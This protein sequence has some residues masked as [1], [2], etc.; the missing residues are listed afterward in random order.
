MAVLTSVCK[1]S[2][3]VQMTSCPFC[4]EGKLDKEM[5]LDH[6]AEEVHAFSLRALPW[7]MEIE[8]KEAG[9]SEESEEVDVAPLWGRDL[10]DLAK[11]SLA[12]E[13]EA[14]D[15]QAIQA[16]ERMEILPLPSFG[17]FMRFPEED[18]NQRGLPNQWQVSGL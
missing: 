12:Q 9:G 5:L 1:R 7:D 17:S 6:V 14:M 18:D 15:E 11:L 3:P 16:S 13:G 4:N 2:A 10:E 8:V